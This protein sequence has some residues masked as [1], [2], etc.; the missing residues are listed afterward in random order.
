MVIGLTGFV[1][2]QIALIARDVSTGAFAPVRR[3]VYYAGQLV[4]LAIV[5]RVIGSW[6]GV[7]RDDT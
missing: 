6:I 2:D 1:L 4:V 7:G 3:I 5:I